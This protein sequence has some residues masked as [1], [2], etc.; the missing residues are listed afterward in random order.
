MVYRWKPGAHIKGNAQ[1]IGEHL[2]GLRIEHS[3]LTARLIVDDAKPESSPTHALFEW[4]DI[5]AADRWRLQQAQHVLACVMVTNDDPRLQE[6]TRAFV[7]VSEDD[8]QHYTSIQTVLSEPALMDQVLARAL[9]EL[10]AF[11]RK[12]SGLEQ[13][14]GVISA[15]REVRK[16]LEQA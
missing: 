1:V 5:A 11:E 2:E 4:D 10:E 14:A 3:G 8:E 13:L 6:P 15:A 7:V 16:K 12:Y 9:R